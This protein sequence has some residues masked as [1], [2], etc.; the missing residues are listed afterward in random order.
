[1]RF[2]V[3]LCCGENQQA[4]ETAEDTILLVVAAG[5]STAAGDI[6]ESFTA[7]LLGQ[8]AEWKG[9]VFEAFVPPAGG[10]Q[11]GAS[12]AADGVADGVQADVKPAAKPAPK[13]KP[14]KKKKEVVRSWLA[15]L[16]QCA[17]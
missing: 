9:T 1:M 8:P 5:G 10:S 11:P 3:A 4:R 6:W 14:A 13:A 15:Q 17:S 12:P 16:C 7:C 2:L